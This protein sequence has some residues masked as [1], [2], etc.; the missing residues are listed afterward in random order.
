[1]RVHIALF[2]AVVLA[3]SAGGTA[4]AQ[5]AEE[6]KAAQAPSFGF[7]AG[8]ELGSDVLPTGPD[9][10]DGNP[11][12]EA[13][14]RLGFKPDLSFGKIGLGFDL[15]VRFKLYPEPDQ[16]VEIYPDDW[17]PYYH[18]NGKSFFDIYLPKILY[19]RY[20]LKGED[21][22]FAKLGSIDDLTLGNGFIDGEY[23]NMRFMPETRIFGLDL[24]IDGQLFGFPYIGFEALTGNLARFDVIGGRLFA[25]PLID[26]E[27]PIVKNTQV[28]FTAAVDR[29]PDLYDDNLTDADPIC[30]YGADVTV[31]IIG[32]KLFPLAAF[33]DVAFEPNDTMGAMIGAGGRIIGI[34]T[35]GAQL[36]LLQDG[37][38]PVYFDANYD[39]Y[40]SMKYNVMDTTSGGGD[41]YAG[42]Y[43]SLGTTLIEDKLVFKAS[44]DG[45]FK[46]IPGTATDSQTD[47]PH[48]KATFVFGEGLL[49]GFFFDASYEKYFIGRE[50]GFFSDLVDPTDAVVGL[51]VNYKT[52]A[53]VLTLKYDA[54]WDPVEERFNVSS[55]LS[56]SMQF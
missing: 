13:W 29:E 28:G 11:T 7:R 46:A 6:E 55:S 26:T 24:G 12:N 53:S 35:Y 21:P 3:C 32:G 37:F 22:L 25:R 17:I 30:V 33:A 36:R 14:T 39:L 18:D 27:I 56:A 47:Y 2:M 1:M 15:S 23:S 42:W 41:F 8:I 31:P 34:F 10:A 50:D 16:A 9:D 4:F 52:G 48:A 20:G 51:A 54:D 38:I 43:A 5:A 40:R 44:L 19:L 49:G 45:P